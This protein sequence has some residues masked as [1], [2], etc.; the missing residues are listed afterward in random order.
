[1]TSHDRKKGS[2]INVADRVLLDQLLSWIIIEIIIKKNYLFGFNKNLFIT[3]I[4]LKFNN[5]LS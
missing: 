1:M 5:R 4:Y 2:K 3:T